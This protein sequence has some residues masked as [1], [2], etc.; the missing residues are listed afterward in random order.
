MIVTDCCCCRCTQ[1]LELHK[2][3]DGFVAT[4]DNVVSINLPGLVCGDCIF[5]ILKEVPDPPGIIAVK[6]L[7]EDNAVTALQNMKFLRLPE[8]AALFF[9]RIF[10]RS[11]DVISAA[12]N[13]L[14]M[15]GLKQ[16]AHL[17]F[18]DR[19]EICDRPEFVKLNYVAICGMDGEWEKGMKLLEQIASDVPRYHVIKGNLL[20]VAGEWDLAAEQWTQAIMGDPTH[21]VAFY[22]LGNYYLHFKH[23]YPEAERHLRLCCQKFPD[24]R[25]FR[26][27]LGDSLFFQDRKQEALVEYQ[28]ALEI[29]DYSQEVRSGYTDPDSFEESLKKMIEQCQKARV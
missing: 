23:D 17:F 27:F 19:L 29:P 2:T 6:V 24:S 13:L 4:D 9:S 11:A 28:I 5:E 21:N 8:D 18:E 3:P 16:T 7:T 1:E 14:H 26:A 20:R 12:G 10:R 22:N 25:R 15:A